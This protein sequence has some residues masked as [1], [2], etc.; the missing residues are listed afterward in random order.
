[1]S[2][3]RDAQLPIAARCQSA[4]GRFGTNS[5]E[6][7]LDISLAGQCQTGCMKYTRIYKALS[8]RFHIRQLVT[9]GTARCFEVT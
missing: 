5:G 1:M 4:K 3:L 8:C 9:I 7:E 6:P 2:Y